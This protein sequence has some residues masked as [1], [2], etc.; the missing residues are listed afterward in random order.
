MKFIAKPYAGHFRE[1]I[2]TL[3]PPWLSGEWGGRLLYSF[4]IQLDAIA[5]MLRMGV[6]QRFPGACES[7]ALQ[8]IG[9]DRV[10]RRGVTEPEDAYRERLTNAI[11]SWKKAGSALAI[12]E[13]LGGYFA[14]TPPRIRYVVN[15]LDE[16][17]VRINDWWTLENGVYTY[18]RSDPANWDWDGTYPPGRF[19]III[20][21]G[22][23]TPWYWGDGHVWGGG[24]SWGFEGSGEFIQ[25]IRSLVGTW[26]AAGSHAGTFNAGLDSGLIFTDD[27]TIFDPTS[28]PGDP[29]MPDGTWADPLNRNPNALYLSG[30]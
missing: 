21:G 3:A 19:W 11:P 16:N 5:E 7:E 14:P 25:D 13:Q 15:G 12:L 2:M 27:D 17:G 1:G 28:S 8:Y 9:S 30:V 6:L 22:V 26:K 24:Q 10:I 20:Y 23:L 4:G 18:H 29:G